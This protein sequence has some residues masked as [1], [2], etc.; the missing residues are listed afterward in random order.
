MLIGQWLE[1]PKHVLAL[2]KMSDHYPHLGHAPSLS[3][4]LVM[5]SGFLSSSKSSSGGMP[6]KGHSYQIM[7][8]MFPLRTLRSDSPVRTSDYDDQDET[9]STD[10]DNLNPYDSFDFEFNWGDHVHYPI[11][12]E[13][14]EVVS[15]ENLT[16]KRCNPSDSAYGIY[17]TALFS[18]DRPDSSKKIKRSHSID[19][20][21]FQ[22]FS[23]DIDVGDNL[24]D[25]KSSINFFGNLVPPVK[26]DYLTGGC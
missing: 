8:G 26:T 10:L 1:V 17:L 19:L 9:L 15:R 6:I 21:N 13:E 5:G 18:D 25:D 2:A 16:K 12:P 7:R 24:M 22:D 11:V 4:Q 20:K 23:Q 3:I 14:N